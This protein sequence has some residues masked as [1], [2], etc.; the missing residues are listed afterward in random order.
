MKNNNLNKFYI[1]AILFIV[2]AVLFPGISTLITGDNDSKKET[3]STTSISPTPKKDSE[4]NQP[5]TEPEEVDEEEIIVIDD[6]D[7]EPIESEDKTPKKQSN[8]T[9]LFNKIYV[10]YAS[11]KNPFAFTAV[12]QY[13]KSSGFKYKSKKPSSTEVGEIKVTAK[14]GDYVYFVFYSAN[15]VEVIMT[16]SYY[17]KEYDSEV[18]LSNYSSDNSQ[19]YDKLSTHIIGEEDEEVDDVDDQREFLF[20]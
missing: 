17:Q 16:V 9:K 1:F 11:R 19:A 20:G 7:E 18:S 12:E 8:A 2:G 14:N 6:T 10:P 3:K 4:Q 13:V 5:T 15:N